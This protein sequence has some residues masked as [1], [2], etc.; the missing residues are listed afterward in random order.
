MDISSYYREHYVNTHYL[1][2]LKSELKATNKALDNLVK[3][4]ERGLPLTDSVIGRLN[5]NEERKQAL[6]QA[7]EVEEARARAAEDDVSI[8]AYFERYT[9]ADFD[10]DQVRDS[11]LEYFVDKIYLYDDHIVIIGFQHEL[12]F[13]E[14]YDEND[15]GSS[16]FVYDQ[17]LGTGFAY[18]AD[19]GTAD[20]VLGFVDDCRGFVSP[21]Y[22]RPCGLVLEAAQ[23]LSW[24]MIHS[25]ATAE[26][27]AIATMAMSQLRIFFFV[28]WWS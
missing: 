28:L 11:I 18:P 21:G 27:T 26:T 14:L 25:T 20:E 9:N 7:I 6:Q 16:S 4:V 5:E 23:C 22:W 3:A 15:D 19:G 1:D 10:D 12:M 17:S 2:G 13:D 24:L 8:R